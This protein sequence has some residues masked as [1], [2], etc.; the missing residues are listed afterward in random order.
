MKIECPCGVEMNIPKHQETR[1]KYCSKTCFYRYR[2]RS[3][4][5]TY[6]VVSENPGWFRKG[7][8]RRLGKKMSNETKRKLSEVNKGKHNGRATEIKKGQFL[9]GLHPQWKGD[10]VGYQA[11]HRWV[12]KE[13]GKPPH[14]TACGSSENVQWA[15]K[16][17]EYRRDKD[18][19]IRLCIKCHNNYDKGTWGAIKRKYGK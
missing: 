8:K 17:R 13:L 4:G 10:S 11:L 15:N 18:D 1:K 19:W 5:L 16:S 7:E 6:N 9:R 2:K 14:C 12:E 3:S